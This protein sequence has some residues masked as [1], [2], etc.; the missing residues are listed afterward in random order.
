M[1]LRGEAM[2]LELITEIFADPFLGMIAGGGAIA[3]FTMLV[4][5]AA[6]F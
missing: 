2:G 3:M 6:V 1:E 5:Y 4:Q